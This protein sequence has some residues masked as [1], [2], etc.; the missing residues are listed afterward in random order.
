MDQSESLEVQYASFLVRLWHSA[1]PRPN[2]SADDWHGEVEH[3]QSGRRLAFDSLGELCR[4]MQQPQ[5]VESWLV[6]GG[7]PQ[8]TSQSGVRS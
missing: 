3:I 5:P 8:L 6:D 4:F 1:E 2:G 7:L